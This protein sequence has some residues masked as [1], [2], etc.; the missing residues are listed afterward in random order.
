MSL[1]FQDE[2]VY[3]LSLSILTTSFGNDQE[4]KRRN[5]ISFPF[6]INPK[7]NHRNVYNIVY[8]FPAWQYFLGFSNSRWVFGYVFLYVLKTVFVI[9]YSMATLFWIFKITIAVRVCISQFITA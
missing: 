8:F 2:T 3:P 1:Q 6:D 7:V 5:K 9:L 4:V